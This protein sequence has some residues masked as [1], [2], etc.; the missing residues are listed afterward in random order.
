MIWLI[1]NF[2]FMV[3]LVTLIMLWV[4]FAFDIGVW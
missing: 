1:D 4:A 2:P 3:Y